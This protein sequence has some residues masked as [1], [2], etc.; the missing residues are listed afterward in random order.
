M[1]KDYLIY[2]AMGLEGR[3]LLRISGVGTDRMKSHP[4][5][6]IAIVG[7]TSVVMMIHD[8]VYPVHQGVV[9]RLFYDHV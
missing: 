2:P 4:S 3:K 7:K 1:A 8:M 6:G 9:K 5:I